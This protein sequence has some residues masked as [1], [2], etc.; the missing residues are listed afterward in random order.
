MQEIVGVRFK[1]LGK[2]YFFDPDGLKLNKNESVIVETARGLELGEVGI[3]NR[4]M[5]EDKLISAL[6]KVIRIATEEDKKIFGENEKK[7]QEAY[8]VCEE[9][10]KKQQR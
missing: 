7:A 1:K 5:D 3:A 9:K 10:I 8:V 2:I 6:K 4:M